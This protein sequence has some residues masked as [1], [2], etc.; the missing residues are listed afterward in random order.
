MR[1]CIALLLYITLSV[2]VD[3]KIY[4]HKTAKFGPQP[5]TFDITEESLQVIPTEGC[6]KIQNDLTGKIA[7]IKRSPQ[8]SKQTKN[9]CYFVDKTYNAQE[10]GA[11]GVIIGAIEYSQGLIHMYAKEENTRTITI[12]S[13]FV[14]KTTY[15]VLYEKEGYNVTLN[16]LGEQD[17]ADEFPIPWGLLMQFLIYLPCIFFTV[18]CIYLLGRHIKKTFKYFQRT[19]SAR[20]LP[21][22]T[23]SE[24]KIH[25]NN[26]CIC[27]EDF[28]ERDAIKVLPCGHGYH[29]ACIDKWL[30]DHS[31]LCP[32]CKQSINTE[33]THGLIPQS[34]LQR[35]CARCNIC[36]TYR[37]QR[38]FQS[39]TPEDSIHSIQIGRLLPEQG[40][41]AVQRV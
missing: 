2:K 5:G 10:A 20:L 30:T 34:C 6:E 27:I 16:Q 14:E 28:E 25:N 11:V 24:D 40:Q 33:P 35:T 17:L 32:M 13:V 18:F 26:C 37:F 29:P 8:N 31:D 3:D 19:E 21:I 41:Q 12:P 9:S 1:L 4:N 39:E 36:G 7:L 15:D 23:Y 22:L 38:I